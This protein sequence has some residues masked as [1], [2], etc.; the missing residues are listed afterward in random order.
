MASRLTWCLAALASLTVLAVVAP[1]AFGTTTS[2]LPGNA[3]QGKQVFVQFCGKCHTMAAAGSAGTLGPNLDKDK[4][5]FTDVVSA[6]EEGV[7]G[8][9]AEYVLRS[10]TFSEIYD[11]AK[12]VVTHRTGS[13]VC[14]CSDGAP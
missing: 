6:I 13:P 8:I 7:G 14:S 2:A 10:V 1:L 3:I 11:V 5:S 12:F 4:V 9:Q